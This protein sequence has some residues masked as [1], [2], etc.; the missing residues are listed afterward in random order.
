MFKVGDFVTRKKYNGDVVFVIDDIRNNIVY[1]RGVDV[2]LY[3]DSVYDDLSPVKD[4]KKKE[5]ITEVRSL[6]KSKYFYIPS[7]ILHIDSDESYMKRCIE[8]YEKQNIR[9][10][11]EVIKEVN[12]KDKVCSLVRKYNPGI[13]VITGHDAHYNKKKDNKEYK[14]SD[15]YISTVKEIR[16]CFGNNIVIYAGACQSNFEGLMK[17]GASFASSPARVNIHALDPAIVASYI[18]LSDV[19]EVVDVSLLCD[20]THFGSKG[21]G[22]LMIKGTMYTGYPRGEKI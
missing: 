9:C 1:L 15:Y 6:S 11:G 10:H 7:F 12:L 2:R 13:V 5:I 20:K 14:N 4:F 8:Y 17:A 22:G 16:K 21:I 3:A 19:N 18:A